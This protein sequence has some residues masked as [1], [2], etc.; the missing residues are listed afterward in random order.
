[1]RSRRIVAV[2]VAYNRAELLQ[3]ALRA[4]LSQTRPVDDIVV[5]DNASTDDSF[6]VARREAPGAH[7]IR[8]TENTGG[9]GGFA[10]G[11]ALALAECAPDWVWVMDD[12]TIPTPTALEAL[13]RTLDESADARRLAALA[14]RV[15]WMNGEE[16]PMNTPRER[17]FVS[18]DE[19]RRA[20]EVDCLPVRSVSFVSSMYRADAIRKYGLPIADYF[21]WND[22]FEFSTRLLRRSRGLFV[23]ASVVVH[24]TKAL[25]STDGDPGP[26]FY[27]E[28]RNKLWMFFRSASLGPLE[29]AVY[30]ASSLARWARTVVTSAD[31]A[32]LVDG[33]RR[34]LRDGMRGGPR[35]NGDILRGAGA[36]H[37]VI[38]MAERVGQ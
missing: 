11:I 10:A 15:E 31:R 19:R 34:G 33:L 9:A 7:V 8:L 1:M 18:A 27:Y 22:D 37:P 4:L 29:K 17:P 26:R 5:I 13:E 25:A 23:P 36:P 3:E 2:M 14:S 16:H 28:V 24:K 6:E 32:V 30:G 38:E 35:R 21:I 12:D 20:R